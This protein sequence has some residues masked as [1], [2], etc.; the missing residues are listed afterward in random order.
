MEN[1]EKSWQ[2]LKIKKIEKKNLEHFF[3]NEKKKSG[4]YFSNIKKL[5][6]ILKD[7]EKEKEKN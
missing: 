5:E 1:G 3:K 6:N 4:K 7:M 2:Y